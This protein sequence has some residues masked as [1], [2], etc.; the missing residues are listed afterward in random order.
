MTA[1]KGV[2]DPFWPALVAD[3]QRWGADPRDVAAV[4]FSESG[5]KPH[6]RNA[7]GCLGLNQLCP[8]N[9]HLFAPL[10]PDEYLALE[11]SEQWAQGAGKFFDAQLDPH[12][13]AHPQANTSARDIYWVNYKP[14][15][16]KLG[17]PDDY[18]IG[19]DPKNLPLILPADKAT[20]M[21]RPA[22]LLA[23][24]ARAQRSDPA[25][26]TT[27]LAAIAAAE[28]GA[29]LAQNGPPAPPRIPSGAAHVEEAGLGAGPVFAFCFLGFIAARALARRRGR[30]A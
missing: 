20:S 13:G 28:Q 16:F 6:I 25:K 2:D 1:V 7:D 5:L 4:L 3:A 17:A 21:V 14:N 29:P 22:G 23:L 30:Y 24:I 8:V 18:E 15:T 11:A 10:T 27:V 19:P 12:R 26:W 9:H